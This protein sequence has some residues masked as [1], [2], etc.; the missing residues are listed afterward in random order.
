MF[1]VYV[2]YSKSSAKLYIRQSDNLERRFSEHQRGSARYTRGR[3]PWEI[4]L[5]EEYLTRA[6]TMSREKLLKSGRGREG[7][8]KSS[9]VERVRLRRVNR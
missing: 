5:T 9:M 6:E 7:S 3:G 2:L 1:S 4:V 8:K